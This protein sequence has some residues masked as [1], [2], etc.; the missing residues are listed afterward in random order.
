MDPADEIISDD[1]G[2]A[3]AEETIASATGTGLIPRLTGSLSRL[4]PADRRQLAEDLHDSLAQLLALAYL[5]LEQLMQRPR[6]AGSTELAEVR[7]LL[8]D[9]IHDTRSLIWE[10]N[11]PELPQYGLAAALELLATELTARRHQQVT[12][13]GLETIPPLD[14]RTAVELFRS[15]RELLLNVLKHARARH[16]QLVAQREMDV[17]TLA[18][19]DDGIGA[20]TESS[21]QGGTGGGQGLPS[22]RERLSHLNASLELSDRPEGGT[23]ASIRLP[24]AGVPTGELQSLHTSSDGSES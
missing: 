2:D 19:L 10:L 16:V 8:R 7:D 15:I 11:P 13:Q 21:A 23:C 5:K 9:S 1:S 3:H 14:H 17:L 22:V 12:V 6:F 20:Q 24:L 4:E 18:V